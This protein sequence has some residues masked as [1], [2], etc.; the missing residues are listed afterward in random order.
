MQHEA[1]VAQ[2]RSQC[3]ALRSAVTQVGPDA[4][5]PTCPRWTTRRLVGHLAKVQV[6]VRAGLRKISVEDL[7]AG[8]PPEDWDSLLAWWDEHLALLLDELADPE[9]PA[10]LPFDRAPQTAGAWARRQAHEAAIHRLD[11]EH[12]RAGSAAAD[13]VPG[14]AFD[15]GFAADGIEELLGWLVP[16][17]DS[18][19]SAPRAGAVLLGAA[20]AGRSWTVRVEPGVPPELEAGGRTGDATVTGTADAV[21]RQL[22]G[23]PSHASVAGD[24]GLLDPLRAP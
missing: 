18:A 5:V 17:L 16:R 4:D 11:A 13:A 1:F 8:R 12:A 9:A 15:P 23:R 7:G 19:K 24:T 21:Y 20:D 10:W 22:W 2:I 6:W 14:L 3:T